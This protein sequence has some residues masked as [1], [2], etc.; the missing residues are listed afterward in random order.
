MEHDKRCDLQGKTLVCMSRG[1]SDSC[2]PM[3]RERKVPETPKLV[4]R[5]T[6][7]TGNNALQVRGQKFKGRL[8]L[9]PKVYRL[10]TS[11][12][13]MLE[14]ALSTAIV[15][16]KCLSSWIIAHGWVSYRVVRT[17]RPHFCFCFLFWT[18]L[19][20]KVNTFYVWVITF[21]H[22]VACM[23]CKCVCFVAFAMLLCP[24]LH[25][26]EIDYY[27]N[28]SGVCLSVH[29]SVCRVPWPNSRTER[30]RRP[31]L[32]RWSPSHA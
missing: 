5:L 32:S 20:L 31:K 26:G 10:R 16:Y 9:K 25:R 23:R 22:S 1:P 14:H 2:W 7:T 17:R 18:Q 4:R 3:S 19:V 27:E 24:D 30:L 15:R 6:T 21:V 12:L 28:E 13:V 11:N 29:P 8:M